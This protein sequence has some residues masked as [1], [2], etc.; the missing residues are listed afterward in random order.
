M[1][2]T[3]LGGWETVPSSITLLSCYLAKYPLLKELVLLFFKVLQGMKYFFWTWFPQTSV[4]VSLSP[5]ASVASELIFFMND[6]RVS[7]ATKETCPTLKACSSLLIFHLL[8]SFWQRKLTQTKPRFK[9]LRTEIH[10][11]TG[12]V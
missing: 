6:L 5:V 9:D 7:N 4:C 1:I 3:L 10:V 8:G 11:S 2:L 12:G